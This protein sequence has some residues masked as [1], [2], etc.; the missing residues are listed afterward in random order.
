M[1]ITGEGVGLLLLVFIV[2]AF[3][4]V[5]IIGMLIELKNTERKIH[6]THRIKRD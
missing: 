1:N 3:L 4:I 5:C 2:V 6:I